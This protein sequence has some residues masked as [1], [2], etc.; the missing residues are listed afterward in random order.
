MFHL[1]AKRNQGQIVSPALY[2]PCTVDT[3][4]CK[5]SK[6]TTRWSV[7]VFFL[8]I[9]STLYGPQEKHFEQSHHPCSNPTCQARKFVVFGSQ[10]D[11]QAHMVEEHSA[12]M[13]S[14]D[15]KDARRV[16]AA[17]EFQMASS[18]SNVRRGGGPGGGVGGG[19]V[20]RERGQHDSQ[21]QLASQP[22]LSLENRRS[23]FGLH[24]MTER[25]A[26]DSSPGPSRHQTPSPPP[27]SMDPVSAESVSF[28]IFF[29][30]VPVCP[31]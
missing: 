17:F 8:A 20:G 21:P 1:Q 15:K 18:S 3:G 4:G 14:R 24:L 7:T 9:I 31:C 30:C 5:A 26:N 19:G 6:I 29:P 2:P 11:L 13:S 12:E 10:I 23:L 25:D 27:P 16:D 28:S 22:A